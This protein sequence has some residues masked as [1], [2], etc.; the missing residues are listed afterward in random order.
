MFL[1]SS[2]QSSHKKIAQDDNQHLLEKLLV[3]SFDINLIN[4]DV[5]T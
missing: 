3:S 2:S 1:F 4:P 5:K